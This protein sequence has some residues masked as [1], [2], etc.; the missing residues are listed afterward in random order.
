MKVHSDPSSSEELAGMEPWEAMLW[1]SRA[2]LEASEAL[3]QAML[4]GDFSFQY[5]SSR[6][7]LH[8]ARQGIE[9]FLKGAIAA[10][11]EAPEKLGHNLN[12]LHREYRRLYPELRF[13]FEVPRQFLVSLNEELFPDDTDLFHRELD[14]RHGYAAD[15]RGT[16]FATSEVFDPAMM[17]EELGEL[18][19]VSQ[20]IEWTEL[21]PYLNTM[22]GRA[23]S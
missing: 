12:K 11:G 15:R 16:S 23:G 5:S 4:E 22:L 3:C 17:K 1:L 13:Y 20:I 19:R 14:Q 7:V 21:R 18:R 6:V 9:L 10:H 8:L 2:Y